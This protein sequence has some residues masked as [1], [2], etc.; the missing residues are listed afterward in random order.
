MLKDDCA[1][2]SV[3]WLALTIWLNLFI[4]TAN[5]LLIKHLIN[6]LLGGKQVN[7]EQGYALWLLFARLSIGDNKQLRG[8]RN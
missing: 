7:G 6:A 8:G 3:C 2:S 1:V 5:L 4:K